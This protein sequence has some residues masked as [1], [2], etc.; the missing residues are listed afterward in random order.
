M[1]DQVTYSHGVYFILASRTC[2]EVEGTVINVSEV[3]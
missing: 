2:L 3:Q 1:V